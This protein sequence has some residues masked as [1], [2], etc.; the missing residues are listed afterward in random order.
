MWD[1]QQAV[2]SYVFFQYAEG[3]IAAYSAVNG[4]ASVPLI[5]R[6]DVQGFAPTGLPTVSGP[7]F[8]ATAN[9][10]VVTIHDEPMAL[11]EIRSLDAP[12]TVVLQFP[13]GSAIT[14]IAHSNAWPRSTLGFTVNGGRGSLILGAGTLN[15]NGGRVVAS[16]STW[17]YLAVKA[18]PSF[19][20]N[21][22]E[23]S[24]LLDAFVSGRLVAEYGLVAMSE[25]GWIE[26][27]AQFRNSIRTA[28]ES[29]EFSKTVIELG[30]SPGQG[31]I[32][33]VA[34][35]PQTMPADPSHHLVVKLNGTD[36]T[37]TTDAMA[38]LYGAP[39]AGDQPVFAR[40]PMNATVLAVYIPDLRA[41]LL[42]ITSLPLPP[43][44]IDTG[45]LAAMV[46]A[47]ALVSV[48]AAEMFRHRPE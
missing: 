30:A 37:E 41:T 36:V 32:I 15:V 42:D 4:S 40:L 20:P 12:R 38:P 46:A 48:A 34:F 3:R 21:R 44:A 33:L 2:G 39:A 9:S 31:G 22:A 26:N 43:S 16:L 25:G 24:A 23:R 35:D 17:D 7:T 28:S 6:V 19:A 8:V 29:V 45:T 5:D 1:G 27:S 14:E 11:L 13:S 10:T 18:I 47:L